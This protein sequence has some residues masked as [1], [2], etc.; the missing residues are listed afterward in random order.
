MIMNKTLKIIL[1]LVGIGGV[2][3]IIELSGNKEKERVPEKRSLEVT[4]TAYNSLKG[5]TQGNPFETAWGDTLKEGMKAIAIS[6]DLL[7]SGL[8]YR[9]KVKIEGLPGK[10]VVLDKMNA[11]WTKKIDIYMG[12]SRKDA[13]DWGKKKVTIRWKEQAN[14]NEKTE[15]TKK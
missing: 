1:L 2:L 15:Q 11:R 6:R 13:L 8:T 14:K 9:T 4:A 10:Y 3:L 7:D 5:Q 12:A